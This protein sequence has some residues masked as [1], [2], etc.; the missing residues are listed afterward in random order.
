MNPNEL[1]PA[2]RLCNAVDAVLRGLA[3]LGGHPLVSSPS[4]LMG[5]ADQPNSFC[6][7][8]LIEVEAA[9]QFLARCGMLDGS[10][11]IQT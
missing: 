4:K 2:D 10:L 3:E 11:D 1:V 8:T 6:D 9:E 7:F 5:H